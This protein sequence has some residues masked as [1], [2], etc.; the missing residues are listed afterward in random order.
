MKHHML[1]FAIS[2]SVQRN[3]HLRNKYFNLIWFTVK[4]IIYYRI[5]NKN[6]P[7]YLTFYSLNGCNL[8]KYCILS[9]TIYSEIVVP[10]RLSGKSWKLIRVV[11]DRNILVATAKPLFLNSIDLL[12]FQSLRNLKNRSDNTL[13]LEF[14]AVWNELSFPKKTHFSVVLNWLNWIQK[15]PIY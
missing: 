10:F 14:V 5:D 15:V 8:L 1:N 13:L 4:V 6:S 9:V 11:D 7:L 2:R 12:A 3:F